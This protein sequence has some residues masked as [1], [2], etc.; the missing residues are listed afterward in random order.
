MTKICADYHGRTATTS[1]HGPHDALSSPALRS[2][3]F[4]QL[5][6]NA[7]EAFHCARASVGNGP[8][9]QLTIL[10]R[11]DLTHRRSLVPLDVDLREGSGY[12]SWRS[13]IGI[14]LYLVADV[15]RGCHLMERLN[16]CLQQRVSCAV[17]VP[18]VENR[19]R[20]DQLSSSQKR[21]STC[22]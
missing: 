17:V 14:A 13:G 16:P 8:D 3:M 20:G 12:T 21:C 10:I 6:P 15:E 11:V 22:L 5:G 9:R 2:S 19:R 7:P 18:E 4:W 1:S